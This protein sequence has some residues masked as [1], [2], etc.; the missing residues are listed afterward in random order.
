[1]VEKRNVYKLLVENA[2]GKIPLGK[3]RQGVD[4]IVICF[5]VTGIHRHISRNT[6]LS[7]NSHCRS[8][9]ST[10]TLQQ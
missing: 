5:E 6:R 2:E 10:I 7:V 1:M 3:P 4:N 9:E 8:N